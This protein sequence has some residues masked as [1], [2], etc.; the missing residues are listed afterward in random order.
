GYRL[1]GFLLSFKQ[2]I[3]RPQKRSA[4]WVAA[5]SSS[6]DSKQ[7][8]Y[9]S[10]EVGPVTPSHVTRDIWIMLDLRT[11]NIIGCI[12]VKMK[13]DFLFGGGG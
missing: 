5:V 2:K 4:M 6:S 12:L 8:I 13:T 11:K 10:V 3:I 9:N 1:L 7:F